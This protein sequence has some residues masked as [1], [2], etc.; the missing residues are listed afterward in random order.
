MKRRARW[1]ITLAM[2]TGVAWACQDAAAPEDGVPESELTFLRFPPDLQPAVTRADSFYAVKGDNRELVLRYV[3]EQPGEEGERFLEFRVPGDALLRRPDGTLFQERDSVLIR[4]EVADDGRFLFD[5]QPSG[6]EFDQDH[7][8]RLRVTYRALDGDIDGDGDIDD[9]D[10]DLERELRLW[11]Q[12]APGGLWYP[13]G[14]I[15]LEDVD[16]I[17]G[18]I[19]GFTGFA[20]AG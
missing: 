18:E 4:V 11:R 6:L 13:M 9:D 3:P 10:D 20:I 16:E 14:V 7:A 8:P 15:R 19:F 5:F 12:E 17:D 2:L 1:L